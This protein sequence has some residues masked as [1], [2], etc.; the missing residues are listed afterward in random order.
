MDISQHPAIIEDEIVL[1]DDLSLLAAS[2]PGL[3]NDD[4]TIN[5]SPEGILFVLMAGS[6]LRRKVTTAHC[7][8]T[9]SLVSV[10]KA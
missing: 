9:T 1:R 7:C 10:T 2:N 8:S 5:L 3:I 4:G 6:G